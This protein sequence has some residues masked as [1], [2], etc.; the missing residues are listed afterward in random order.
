[1]TITLET[2]ANDGHEIPYFQDAVY[3]MRRHA[4]SMGFKAP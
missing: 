1:M 4:R 2:A 3:G